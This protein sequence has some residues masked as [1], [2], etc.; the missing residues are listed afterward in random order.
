MDTLRTGEPCKITHLL[1]SAIAILVSADSCRSA[2]YHRDAP[3]PAFVLKASTQA[4]PIE[5]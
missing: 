1:R 4:F 2:W 5:P 3:V